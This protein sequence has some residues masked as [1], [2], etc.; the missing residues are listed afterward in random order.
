MPTF[1]KII[2]LDLDAF[3]CAVE[4]QRDPSLRGKA[5][6]VGGSPT[7]RGVV[8][9]C[10]YPARR[11]GVHSAM[12]MA[13]AVKICPGLLIVGSDHRRYSMVSRQVM[14][15]LRQLTPLVEQISI[16]EAFLDVSALDASAVDLAQELQATIRDE[17]GLPCSLGVAS[18]KLVAKIVNNV[19][20]AGAKGD[21][22]PN[23]IK[24]V[25][26]GQ[27]TAFL[28]PLPVE[29]LWGVGPKTAETL[30]GLGITTIGDIA[31]W[32]ERD[33]ARRFGKHG[34]DLARRAR[35]LDDRPVVTEHE[36]KSV[37][38]ERTFSRDVSDGVEL[39]H[40]MQKLAAGV[41]KHL[42]RD[43]L[44]GSTV[45]LKLRWADFTTPTRQL[46]LAQPTDNAD[47]IY[48]AALQLFDKLWDGRPVRLIGVGVTGLVQQ[49]RQFELWEVD[50]PAFKEAEAA[51]QRRARLA[52]AVR[53]LEQKYGDDAVRRAS[54]LE[55]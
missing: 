55:E 51:Y 7:G 47:R 5:F 18:N 16:D 13:R 8:A 6:A 21:G 44:A 24:V 50:S 29:E 45:K 22:P 54:E 27:E 3:F 48:T 46:T 1:R 49:A 20:K 19:G 10:S 35:G 11:Y 42:Q 12:P 41:A 15:R 36:A 28:A 39:R 40:M 26:P 4:E 32:D 37:S 33:L 23:A 14:A 34:S 9:S 2:H 31:R 38:Q 30:R 17:L 52:E 25:P 53:K 43:E